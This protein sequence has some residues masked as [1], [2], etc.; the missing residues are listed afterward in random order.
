[1]TD[2]L[3]GIENVG[4][5]GSSAN[6]TL[7]GS[8]VANTLWGNAG[9]DLLSGREGNDTLDGGDGNDAVDFGAL[10]AGLTFTLGG[11]STLTIADGFGFTDVLISIEGV[12]GTSF[13]DTITGNTGDNTLAGGGG[14]NTLVGGGG[15][16]VASFAGATQ[17]I[18]LTLNSVGSVTVANGLGGTDVLV[19]VAGVLG[20]SLADTLTGD[21]LRNWI[22]GNGGDDT[23]WGRGGDDTLVG[24][25]GLDIARY[26]DS[27]TAVTVTLNAAATVTLTD[28]LG[29]T[30]LLLG[31]EGL[32]GSSLADTLVGD[33]N[34]NWFIG[35]GGADTLSGGAGSD[36]ADYGSS[37]IALNFAFNTSGTAIIG[38]GLGADNDILIGMEGIAGTSFND[39]LTGVTT[40]ANIF[41]GRGGDDT[42]AGLS[43][44]GIDT[45]DGGAGVD[46]AVFSGDANFQLFLL[47]NSTGT[48]FAVNT[49]SGAT[50][51]MLVGIENFIGNPF[52][53]TVVGDAGAN[54]I[55]G[56]NNDDTFSDR[57]GNDTIDGGA[58]N[59]WWDQSA[60]TLPVVVNFASSVTDV[61]ALD[62]FGGTD[63][64]INFSR[65]TGGSANDTLTG[66]SGG[67]IIDG[68]AGD[69][70]LA[71]NGG[72]D[73]LIGGRGNDRLNPGAGGSTDR[74][75]FSPATA[76]VTVDLFANIAIDGLGGTDTLVSGFEQVIGG[77]FGS[78][79]T[80]SNA[81]EFFYSGNAADTV[82]GNGGDDV[83]DGGSGFFV[84]TLFG[85]AGDDG[86]LGREGNDLLDGGADNGGFGDYVLYD[87][88]GESSKVTVDL[89]NGFA[90]DG[91]GGTDTLIGI[92]SAYLPNGVGGIAIGNDR[93]N[94]LVG[95]NVADTFFGGKGNDS[96]NGNSGADWAD[97]STS[98]GGLTLALNGGGNVVF[99]DGLGGTDTIVNIEHIRAGA[100]NDTL[101]GD[102]LANSL[103]GNAG[104]DRFAPGAGS[105][106]IDGGSG[107]DTAD[108]SSLSSGITA[109]L[110][111]TIFIVESAG[112][113]DT[114]IGVDNLIAGAGPD[115]FIGDD[116]DNTMDGRGGNDTFFGNGGRDGVQ[117]GGALAAVVADL[118]ASTVIADGLGGTDRAIGIENLIGGAF[119]DTLA[120][121]D[122]DN[123]LFGGGGDDLLLARGG[124]DVLDGGAGSDVADYSALTVGITINI[125]PTI[126]VLDGLGGTDLLTNM[127]GI[128]A[129][130]ADDL[131][132]GDASDNTLGGGAGNDTIDGRAG[133]DV[134]DY[135]S[136]TVGVTID[137]AAGIT[138]GGT[139]TLFP[140]LDGQG[141]SDTLISIEGL[142][143]SAFADV[144]TGDAG[145]NVF[146]GRGGAD[147]LD[148]G[149]GSDFADYG[150]ATTALTVTLNSAGTATLADGL[151]SVDT[152][153]GIEGV[154]GGIG[155]DWFIGDG[156][157]NTLRG[158]NGNDTLAGRSGADTLDG[159]A[160]ADL[161]DFSDATAA[162][163]IT[164]NS[165]GTALAGDGRGSTDVLIGVE[166]L[167]GGDFNDTLI[168]DLAANYLIG[169]AGNDRLIGAGSGTFG[170][171][172]TLDGGVGDDYLVAQRGTSTLVG[173]GGSDTADLGGAQG[174]MGF[175]INSAGTVVIAD[176]GGGSVFTLINIGNVVGGGNQDIIFGDAADNY[177]SGGNNTDTL[178]GGGGNDTLYGGADDRADRLDGGVGNDTLDGGP[179][180]DIARYTSATV[181]M[182]LTVTS[183]TPQT[184]A[185]G[186]GGTDVLISIEGFEGGFFADTL[187]GDA[188]GNSLLGGSGNDFLFGAAGAD[189]LDGGAG[190]DAIDLAGATVGV[191][192]T[193]NGIN[194][195]FFSDGQGST[196]VVRNVENISGSAAG[197]NLGGDGNANSLFGASGDDSFGNSAGNDILDGGVGLDFFAYGGGTLPV[198]VT[199]D[200]LGAITLLD[201]LGG[202]DTLIGIEGIA[203]S[204]FADRMIGDALANVFRPLGGIDFVDG[205][206]GNDLIDYSLASTAITLTLD[207]GATVTVADGQG[208]FDFLVSIE[209]AIGS[210]LA[211]TL[212]GDAADNTFRGGAGSDTFDGKGGLDLVDYATATAGVF[213]QLNAAGT[214]FVTDRQ[215]GTDR[216]TSIEG[217]AGSQF[218]DTLYGDGAANVLYGREG[219]DTFYAGVGN[220]TVDGGLGQDSVFLIDS[221]FGLTLTLD[222]FGTVTLTDTGNGADVLISIEG[223]SAGVLAD[224][225]VG[226]AAGNTFFGNDGNDVIDGAAGNDTLSGGND[227]DTL[228]GGD[229]NDTLDGGAGDDTLLGGAGIDSL[230]GGTGLDV[231][232]YAASPLA[233]TLML[234]SGG[235][236][237]VPDGLGSS[238]TLTGVEGLI[239]AGLDDRLIGDGAANY[240]RGN[241]GADF[242]NGGAGNDVAGFETATAGITVTLNSAGT[243]TLADGLGSTDVL[244]AI[245]GVHGSTL[246]DFV[247]GDS[248]A[249]TFR[250]LGGNDTFDG[251]GGSDLVDFSLATVGVTVVLGNAGWITGVLDGQGGTDVLIA[252]ENLLGGAFDDVLAGNDAAN[253]LT[254][255]AGN[256]ILSGGGGA[257]THAGGAG[258]DTVFGGAGADVLIG[259]AGADVADL[260]IATVGVVVT[261]NG[262]TPVVFAD[263]FGSNDT[264]SGVESLIGSVAADSLNGDTLNNSLFGG[265]G[266]DVLFGSN[267]NDTLNGGEGL[268]IARYDT[269]ATARTVTLAGGSGGTIAVA[270]GLGSGT[271]LLISIEGISGSSAADTLVGDAGA[272]Y[273]RGNRGADTLD[274]AG[275]FD[276][277]GFDSSTNAITLTLDSA[278]SFWVS[279]GLGNS[280][281]LV[282]IEGVVGSSLADTLTGDAVANTFRGLASNDTIDGK[283]GS[284][285][286][287]YLNAGAGIVLTL[288]SLGVV[289]NVNDQQGGLD[290][291]TSIE[292]VAGSQFADTLTG[293]A[294]DNLLIGRN[295]NDTLRG[296]A[297]NDMLDGGVGIDLA[298]FTGATA[299]VTFTVD[300]AATLTVGDGQGGTD[301][302]VSIEGAIGGAFGDVLV[303][304]GGVNSLFGGAGNDTLVGGAGN[305]F[306]NGGGAS[307]TDWNWID[308]SGAASGV[309]L[310][311]LAGAATVTLA[312]GLG[313]TDTLVNI[314]NAIGSAYADALY[315]AAWAN[316][317]TSTILGGAGDDTLGG[318]IA[319]GG[320]NSATLDG[321]AGSDWLDYGS[322]P[323]GNQ[324]VY[325]VLNG[326]GAGTFAGAATHTI[327][328]FENV[329]GSSDPVRADTLIGDG[330]SNTLRG[331]AGSDT[332]DGAGG[333]DVADYLAAVAAVTIDLSAAVLGTLSNVG[334]GQ[335]GLDL[336]ISIEGLAGSVYNDTLAGDAGDNTLLGR[337]GSDLLGGAAGND[338]LDG[339]AGLD[340]AS[341][342]YLTSGAT[343]TLG[344]QIVVDAND[345]DTLVSIEGLAGTS[346]DDRLTG[347]AG[348]NVLRGNAGNDWLDGSGGIDF[349]DFSTA[350][351]ALTIVLDSAATVA[352][353]D[354]LG[355]T[356]S[357]V[358]IEALIGGALA[359]TLTGDAGNN[360]FRGG[361][362]SDTIT[363]GGGS[364]M[365]DFLTAGAGITLTLNSGGTV[366]VVDG[367]GGTDTLLG[368]ADAIGS[369]FNDTLTGDA[370][371]NTLAGR[372]G[373][374]TL[375]GQDGNDFLS[376]TGGGNDSLDGGNGDDL[377]VWM[378]DA[379]TVTVGGGAGSDT[380]DIR[381]LGSAGFQQ[382]WSLT[383]TAGGVTAV[384]GA[385]VQLTPDAAGTL[386]IAGSGLTVN[387]SGLEGI[388]YGSDPFPAPVPMSVMAAPEPAAASISPL[389]VEA[390]GLVLDFN[391]LGAGLAAPLSPD[392]AAPLQL[393]LADLLDFNGGFLGGLTD[394]A[395]SSA[396]AAD[397]APSAADFYLA[398]T[399]GGL[400][401]ADLDLLRQQTG[402]GGLGL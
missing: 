216:L 55:V 196:D 270:D 88:N 230:T 282:S 191:V 325:V 177:I 391:L 296:N 19:D 358:S 214:A 280:D 224:T 29:G 294:V 71:G 163:N 1:M 327:L 300:S 388:Y 256:D 305:D 92:E 189:Y 125:G 113:T 114:L 402:L 93:N 151:G 209:G 338:L 249:N 276:L 384:D 222:S 279:D 335:S 65:L 262:S 297:G 352:V 386:S 331:L 236:I 351:A 186:Q 400:P 320:T 304:D 33:A 54:R 123:T 316:G 79:L 260:S 323:N 298:D 187:I 197:D 201:G 9:D 131:L 267:G 347:D 220:D 89:V 357:L 53:N 292:G 341:Y 213:V 130:S 329:I 101:T 94:L 126:T 250:G 120:G 204:G 190:I 342:L 275:G 389:M 140:A 128:L 143:G 382:G 206:G 378:G 56:L 175:T 84:D 312:D 208:A 360:T 289:A 348:A 62:G 361:A 129:S 368:I 138:S 373:N 5:S 387:F 362:G 90:I 242:I 152:L 108:Y 194:E 115:V 339:G 49:Q 167:R 321:G 109:N 31:I 263:G 142:A 133:L 381:V 251:R 107:I 95:G 254:G 392:E 18:T 227:N 314:H 370:G 179:N 180:S 75:D 166:G 356:D 8:N 67:G 148:G 182:T 349:A 239:A 203:G 160:G 223:V 397:S 51:A 168:G 14:D 353:A 23:L 104:D 132:V 70:T 139:V 231:V 169:G 301:V 205:R 134:A 183:G 253:T 234:N 47:M 302:L 385:N 69:D 12:S 283:G 313:G 3:T 135:G 83:I 80:G 97:Y 306:L 105:D 226:D 308:Y 185:D 286:V 336:L 145:R 38:D 311:L 157:A 21:A 266:D 394:P 207:S 332:L 28:G 102:G 322:G 58:G 35:N 27:A 85:G 237:I 229:G 396:A 383:F 374:D 372:Q 212:T 124:N 22:G 86:L 354:G 367:Q 155:N 6:D 345:T 165:G 164:L 364:D 326:A 309:T 401:A 127:E 371:A 13:D 50:V 117:F 366:T 36:V 264:L 172:D 24:G 153:I 110:G 15:F 328:N 158:R 265:D 176:G 333:F 41:V 44:T 72:N 228:V 319:T 87:R 243:A 137:L 81:A 144:L 281:W 337:D 136:A 121:D 255:G 210:S 184:I 398:N 271:D 258:T 17:P 173:G 77:N 233:Y 238:D 174:T 395:S 59:N 355:G 45:L 252:V 310:R 344:A 277:V 307:A 16:D 11:E 261:L 26:D 225:L 324:R 299:G 170:G 106:Y 284:D 122:G 4:G 99:N 116:G 37:L 149:A 245:E 359:D 32:S 211:D 330:G 64:L 42:L 60:A 380:L 181:G 217:A 244:V 365:V 369:V 295:G 303:G 287:D 248:A 112:V 63:T 91:R 40:A 240:F 235:S 290:T 232:D 274:G 96:I 268:D 20:S 334:D 178:F 399:G 34:N 376:M 48:A 317:P 273:L 30:D 39:V 159:G 315:A 119:N 162:L 100:G 285:L 111:A 202:T 200:S 147:T 269:T 278:A 377:F 218:N 379:G 192:L 43:G 82:F 150:S 219:N 78:T 10:T 272:N 161:A 98:T 198:T 293:D 52:R 66:N 195:V 76:A 73:T 141:G 221:T 257:D 247:V 340:L 363:G 7:I 246:A 57:G 154:G 103:I 259:G 291:L 375:R 215:G 318:L 61:A 199:L 350:T 156:A 74:A 393:S 2:T 188:G 288:N 118:A 390:L 171:T 241:A 343:L 25:A 146:V 68:G 193:L 46:T 346:F